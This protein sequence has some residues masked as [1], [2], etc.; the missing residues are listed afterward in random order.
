MS[1]PAPFA[2]IQVEHHSNV[3]GNIIRQ[4]TSALVLYP[5]AINNLI[6]Q[7]GVKAWR[8]LETLFLYSKVQSDLENARTY[9][10]SMKDLCRQAGQ[11]EHGWSEEA[12]RPIV[13]QL[14]K[15]GYFSRIEGQRR[16][17][18]KGQSPTTWV[19]SDALS[20]SSLTTMP[21]NDV[22][23]IA[24]AAHLYA[25]TLP[26]Q[27]EGMAPETT[28]T[29]SSG[30]HHGYEMDEYPSIAKE[31]FSQV[32]ELI[33]VT[34]RN[35]GW[36]TNVEQEISDYPLAY[37]ALWIIYINELKDIDKPGGFLRSKIKMNAV[38]PNTPMSTTDTI[39]TVTGNRLCLSDLVEKES[40]TLPSVA[41]LLARLE[42]LPL[43]SQDRIKNLGKQAKLTAPDNPTLIW[44]RTVSEALDLE[45]EKSPEQT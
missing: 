27:R 33:L 19:L 44:R 16:G 37:I 3:N 2:W 28:A 36:T 26:A 5:D 38:P 41:S 17:R 22:D 8:I 39:I 4:N 10:G 25:P 15:D 9:V 21:H 13:R 18:N 23:P 7:V 34:L 11:G 32:R 12:V 24:Y 42:H 30:N 1:S 14:E 29:P 40:E 20:L 6:S 31:D 43:L 45:T 35:W